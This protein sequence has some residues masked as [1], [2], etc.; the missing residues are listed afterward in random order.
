M[1]ITG[2]DYRLSPLN[3]TAELPRETTFVARLRFNF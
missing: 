2:Q 1:N 3:L